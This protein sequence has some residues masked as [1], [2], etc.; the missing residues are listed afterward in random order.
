MPPPGGK[1]SNRLAPALIPSTCGPVDLRTLRRAGISVIEMLQETELLA[2]LDRAT[3]KS[4]ARASSMVGVTAGTDVIRQGEP[5]DGL[6]LVLTGRLRVFRTGADGREA[7][8][9]E[10][11][12]GEIVGEGSLITDEPRYASVKASEDSLLIRL[13]RPAFEDILARHPGHGSSLRALIARRQEEEHRERYRP[14]SSEL[15][16]FLR[17]VPLF[18][19]M[20]APQLRDIEGHLRWLYLP[21]G[22]QLMKQ[23]DQPD[24]L[25]VVVGGRLRYEVSD[26]AGRVTRRGD[27]GRG[28]IVGELA[29]VTGEARSATVFALRDCELVKLTE[30]AVNRMLRRSPRV[31]LSLTRTI[32]DRMSRPE[33]ERRGKP[34]T[35]I[36][37]IPITPSVSVR[38]VVGNLEA[39]LRKFGRVARIDAVEVD[40]SLGT[41][42]AVVENDDPRS[43]GIVAF[44]S[45][46]EEENDFLLLEGSIDASSW[47]ERCIRGAD[48]VLLLA[49]AKD[50]PRLSPVEVRYLGPKSSL[51]TPTE[52]VLVQPPERQVA[53][54]TR[55]FLEPRQLERHHHIRKDNRADMERLARHL[56]GRSI[57]LVL[58]GGGARGM[59]HIGV[60]EAFLRRGLPVDMICGTSAG[61]LIGGLFALHGETQ[62]IRRLVKKH[63][64]ESN[65]LNDY[66]FPFISI[67]R[68]AK[69]SRTLEEVFQNALIEDLI[70]PYFAMATNLTATEE[71]V[72]DR[73]PLWKAVRASTSLPGIVPPLYENGQLFV[74]GG[75]L[76]NLPVDAL[77][78]RRAGRILAVDVSGAK[79]N[80]DEQYGKL[81]GSDTSVESPGFFR[82][83]ANRMKGKTTRLVVPTLGSVLLRSTM[84]GSVL[85]VKRAKVDADIYVR[86]PVEKFGLLDW[87]SVESLIE[88]GFQYALENIL[89]WEKKLLPAENDPAVPP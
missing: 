78:A 20:S 3:L 84:V 2:G 86:L 39:V 12:A 74:D 75:L 8:L 18:A 38:E 41:G 76:N 88:I 28:D 43:E 62:T 6:Y 46:R 9:G 47:N 34:F 58:G 22:R 32:A 55:R 53:E 42:S 77:R 51:R 81:I 15:V 60:A 30:S 68:G 24:G 35:S 5:G 57:G 21:G 7:L 67:V 64:V 69:Y 19:S 87:P 83:F 4:V 26:E 63:L 72:F 10:L 70:V 52:L 29:L 50:D 11:S 31:V 14:V 37:L 54:G 85:K 66:T 45:A 17:T 48:R 79:L 44:L 40:R 36:A 89:A 23:G 16:E 65:P 80:Q 49:D 61:A 73:G 27:F 82:S 71:A 13:P 33:S 56:T 59:A 25:Y 1:I